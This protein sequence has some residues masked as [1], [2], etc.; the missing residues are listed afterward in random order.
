MN[1]STTARLEA[2]KTWGYFE[3][4]GNAHAFAREIDSEAWELGDKANNSATLVA[5]TTFEEAELLVARFNT[6]E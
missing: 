6:I 3:D 1:D 5:V 4:V 2:A